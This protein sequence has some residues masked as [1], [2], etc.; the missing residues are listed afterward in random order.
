MAKSGMED[1]NLILEYS[2]IL[3]SLFFQR[4]VEV[5]RICPDISVLKLGEKVSSALL[6]EDG[7]N[8]VSA[9]WDS[10]CWVRYMECRSM[11]VDVVKKRSYSLVR[12][13]KSINIAIC[14]LL[15]HPFYHLLSHGLVSIAI[16]NNQ[17][18]FLETCGFHIVKKRETT[19]KSDSYGKSPSLYNG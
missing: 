8:P 2:Y 19:S 1:C 4:L 14:S 15:N 5:L 6:M 10:L 7:W 16:S 9:E 3:K 17:G 13:G 18:G 11:Q 12:T